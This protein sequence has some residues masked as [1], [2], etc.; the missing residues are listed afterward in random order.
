MKSNHTS[1]TQGVTRSEMN[2][3]LTA[4]RVKQSKKFT[5]QRLMVQAPLD[6]NGRSQTTFTVQSKLVHPLPPN[7]MCYLE[8]I[9]ISN[10]VGFTPPSKYGSFT[11]TTT[12][13]T[14][15]WATGLG[16]TLP[17]LT[18]TANPSGILF[19]LYDYVTFSTT[20]NN[21][22]NNFIGVVTTVTSQTSIVITLIDPTTINSTV[23]IPIFQNP[24][25]TPIG[26]I[27]AQTLLCQYCG[28]NAVGSGTLGMSC[29]NIELLDTISSEVY[30]TN[31]KSYSR[32]IASIPTQPIY[33]RQNIP[34]EVQMFWSAL[35]NQLGYPINDA[36]L[37]NNNTLTFRVSYGAGGAKFELPQPA[38]FGSVV[39]FNLAPNYTVSG[40]N[41]PIPYGAKITSTTGAN[42]YTAP[43]GVSTAPPIYTSSPLIRFTLAFY[44]FSPSN[45][46]DSD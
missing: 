12:G 25:F 33:L 45:D 32:I 9:Y 21:T 19:A 1:A 43:N 16:V 22:T 37:L 24:S 38:S 17:T 35:E 40:N 28:H 5:P 41:I 14:A 23:T 26:I 31:Q 46:S 8:S 39:P 13:F 2:K 4:R 11:A 34:Q 44:P 15:T 27:Q 42:T 18:I 10:V 36:S 7:S 29:I 20:D 3:I 6:A 30:D